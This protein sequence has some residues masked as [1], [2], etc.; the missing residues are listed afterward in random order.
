[1]DAKKFYEEFGKKE[2]ERV[3]I[4]AGT[5]MEYF[6]QLM[7]GNRN[8]SHKLAVKLE[9]SSGG[10]MTRQRLRPDIYGEPSEKAA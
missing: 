1:M 9:T 3:A 8:P 5:T 2:A 6:K 10:R 4:E 7:Y